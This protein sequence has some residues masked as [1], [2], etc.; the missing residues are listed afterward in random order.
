MEFQLKPDSAPPKG[1]DS[2]WV[3]PG[4]NPGV[5]LGELATWGELQLSAKIL[6]LPDHAGLFVL[7]EEGQE[8]PEHSRALPYRAIGSLYL[9]VDSRVS[10]PVSP[11]EVREW[12]GEALAVFHPSAGLVRFCPH[13]LQPAT[14]L[15]RT[16]EMLPTV[17]DRAQP[18]EPPPRKLT[19]VRLTPRHEEVQAY[20]DEGKGD[21]GSQPLSETTL[22]DDTERESL[23]NKFGRTVQE[24][25]YRGLESLGNRAQ[26]SGESSSGSGMGAANSPAGLLGR[27]GRWASGRLARIQ[28]VQQRELNQLVNLLKSDPDKGL[29]FAPPLN[30]RGSRGRNPDHSVSLLERETDF[31]LHALGGGNPASPWTVDWSTYEDLRRQYREAANRELQL[32][33]YRRAAYI[34][35]HLLEDFLAAADALKLGRHFREA[36]LLYRDYVSNPAEAAECFW[37]AGEFDDAEKLFT[38]LRHYER[39]GE[40]FARIGR[41]DRS[42]WAYRK[43]ADHAFQ[44][45]DLLKASRLLLDHL[46]EHE[47]ALNLLRGGWPFSEKAKE[48]VREEYAIL[49]RHGRHEEA[50]TRLDDLIADCPPRRHVSPTL[51]E[52]L[53]EIRETYPAADVRRTAADLVRVEAGKRIRHLST[54]EASRVLAVV[55]ST[56]PEDRLLLRDTLRFLSD[57][58]KEPLPG[59]PPRPA[60]AIDLKLYNILSLPK[61]ADWHAVESFSGGYYA[62]GIDPNHDLLLVRKRWLGRQI[63][64]KWPYPYSGEKLGIE[65]HLEIPGSKRRIHVRAAESLSLQTVELGGESGGGSLAA[66]SWHRNAEGFLGLTFTPRGN[67]WDLSIEG[68]SLVLKC[69]GLD[70]ELI[71]TAHT[72]GLFGAQPEEVARRIAAPLPMAVVEQQVFFAFKSFLCRFHEGNFAWLELPDT[73]TELRGGTAAGRPV[74]AAAMAEAGVGL[75]SCGPLW[76]VWEHHAPEVDACRVRF[77]HDGLLAVGN[78]RRLE[79]YRV[80][81][82][83]SETKRCSWE[84]VKLPGLLGILPGDEP[85]VIVLMTPLQSHFY[86]MTE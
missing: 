61:D 3:L 4:G 69:Y 81:P 73:I 82:N 21:I 74:L 45:K 2:A 83:T 13:D 15:I 78:E 6:I 80:N 44:L 54:R 62:L 29:R 57:R 68:D 64:L 55:R 26:G 75:V 52:V 65:T 16:P 32:Q 9:P 39:L 28:T 24:R 23:A 51:I 36:A 38:E 85:D 86:R 60:G 40:L 67:I 8:A 58:S 42:R 20:L 11:S 72:G 25:F 31:S 37:E 7:L 1:D 79:L 66:G 35:A 50:L 14:T 30:A 71:S 76:G 19:S 22:I 10:P 17:W 41:R 70:G 56:A 18:G 63:E 34:F 49:A 46:G 77:V 27:L 33:R 12:A 59:P 43:A 53:G 48:C 47:Q 5:W 84:T